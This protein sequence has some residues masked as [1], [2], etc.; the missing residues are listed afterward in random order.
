MCVCQYCNKE[1]IKKKYRGCTTCL[2]CETTKRRWM[3]RK[4]LL[5]MLGNK[6]SKCG[7]T[8]NPASMQ[9]HHVNPANKK[10]T[11]YSKN[12]LRKDRIDEARKCI[13]LC[14]NCHIEEHTNKDLLKK[15]GIIP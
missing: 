3:A 1:F 4:E 5:E 2:S 15:F 14:A 7:F 11:L 10:Y 12:L 13:I 6:C 8:G 9:F